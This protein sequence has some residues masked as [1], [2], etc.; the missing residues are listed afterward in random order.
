MKR[1]IAVILTLVLLVSLFPVGTVANAEKVTVKPFYMV[2]WSEPEGDPKYIYGMPGSWTNEGRVTDSTAADSVAVS[3][4]NYG[5]NLKEIAKNMYADFSKRPAGTRYF[6]FAAQRTLFLAKCKDIVDIRHGVELTRNWVDAL[7]AEYKALGGELDGILLDLE[8]IDIGTYYINVN[9]Y[10]SKKNPNKNIYNEIANNEYYKTVLR[11]KLVERGFVFYQNPDPAKYPERSELWALYPNSG[12]EY[13][14]SRSIW[15]QVTQ[16]HLANSMTEAVYEPLIKYFPNAVV[17]DYTTGDSYAWNKGMGHTGSQSGYNTVKAGNASNENFYDYATGYLFYGYASESNRTK[18]TKYQKPASYNDA[19]FADAPFS[20]TNWEINGFKNMLSATDTGKVNAWITFFNYGTYGPGYS[21]TPYYSELIYHLGMANP[22]P[23]IGYIL[24]NEVEAKGYD[25]PHPDVC[26][27]DYN[28]KVVDDLLAEL[29]RV[30]GASDRKAIV[31]PLTWNENFFISGMYAGGRNIWRLTPNTDEVSKENFKVKDKAP[32]FT[33][34]GVTITFPQ[35]RI[36]EDGKVTHVGTCGYWIETPSNVAP[37]ITSTADRYANDPSFSDTFDKYAAGAFTA[38]S[39]L[40]DTFWNI[41]GSANIQ[42]NGSGKALAL[43]GNASV[44]NTKIVQLITAGDYYAK[45][46]AW[47]VA[48]TLPSGNY[49]EV[50][51]LNAGDTDGGIKISGGKVYYDNAGTYQ[52]LS[53]VSLSAGTY[54]VKREVDFRTDGA[55]KCSYSVYDATGNRLGGAD[56]VAMAIAGIPVTTLSLS[57]TGASDA[58]LFDDYKLYPTGVTTCLDLYDAEPGRKLA[59]PNAASAEDV[60]YRLS[61]MN[62]SSQYKVAQIYDAKTGKIIKT[63]QMEPGM[64]GITTGIAE[65]GT[66]GILVSV[67]VQDG[68]APNRPNYENGDFKWNA[69]AYSL[70]LAGGSPDGNYSDSGNSGGNN[71]GSNNGGNTDGSNG[72]GNTDGV[73]DFENIGGNNGGNTD[74]I[75]PSG[76]GNADSNNAGNNGGNNSNDPTSEPGTK[77]GLGG[78]VIALI[79]VGAIVVLLGGA[80]A[81]L[82]F[83]VKPKLTETSPA[84]LLKLAAMTDFKKGKKTN[85]EDADLSATRKIDLPEDDSA[86][87]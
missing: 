82:V 83:V 57:T 71:G 41:S 48:V 13:S 78:G 2:N 55:Y 6:N 80:L 51:V 21:R 35:G 37:I 3:V 81:V 68:T 69:V 85:I 23:F 1:T 62:A 77:N 22:D 38:D 31:T 53:G 75:D 26:E 52:E 73:I 47:E 39:V 60:G 11:P 15:G 25:D 76:N 28:L 87:L 49:G 63:V 66:G 64:D 36:I 12:S 24:K 20:R 50:K 17:S 5:T 58:V 44:T 42:T 59:N 45:Q 34:N 84:W 9:Y 54:T 19:Y 61:W 70:G 79:V 7:C 72:G 14:I 8:Y 67:E 33:V 27:Y 18:R 74:V 10:S 40:P 30:A 16:A 32:T 86:N 56:D 65:A 43:S 46:Q 29:T 4:G